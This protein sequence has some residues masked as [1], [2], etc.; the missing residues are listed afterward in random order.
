MPTVS[1]KAPKTPVTTGSKGMATAAPPN[2]CKMPGPPPPFVPTPLPN[3]GKSDLSP[4]DFTTTVKVEGEAVAIKGSTF[5]S[6]GDVA[7]KG[8]GGGMVSMNCEG[9]TAFVAPGAIDV[10]AEGK[11]VQLLGDATTNNNGPSGS[12]PN[13]STPAVV[14]G[15]GAPAVTQE[16]PCEAIK[17]KFGIDVAAYKDHKG[18]KSV[19]YQSHHILQDAQIKDFIPK[20]DGIA[21]LLTDS[22]SGTEH[23]T[24]TH[25]RQND[26]MNNKGGPG[27]PAGTFGALKEE[28]KAD[29]VAAF[30][31]KRKDANGKPMTKAEAELA[32][33]CLVKDAEKKAKKSAA[34]KGKELN[35]STKVAPPGGCFAA[36]TLVQLASGELR[37]VEDLRVGDRL[38]GRDGALD[39]VRIDSCRH[40]LVEI[41]VGASTFTLASFHRFFMA[42]GR[43]VAARALRV[44][45]SVATLHGPRRLDS[46]RHLPS[47]TA[48][49]RLGS[50]QRS[51]CVLGELGMLVEIGNNGPRVARTEIVSAFQGGP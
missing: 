1:V 48:I 4:K 17:A 5:G 50:A 38:R 6:M 51:A 39:L 31:G 22:H 18:K 8:L 45:D 19:D 30:E 33:D 3:I 20:A 29:L 2:M 12:P 41:S 9:P 15:S 21:V 35:D 11:S 42:D 44:G 40:E 26:R 32:A 10:K 46:V 37:K 34:A 25:E 16:D 27:G 47:Y 43:L 28:A 7:S 24:I 13:T 23:G 49:Y 14:Q 36:G